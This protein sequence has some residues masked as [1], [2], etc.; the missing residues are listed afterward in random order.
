MIYTGDCVVSDEAARAL[1]RAEARADSFLVHAGH[2]EQSFLVDKL[3][4]E[5]RARE[6]KQMPIDVT[7]G[8]PLV[9][10]P[11]P[12]GFLERMLRPWIAA[13]ALDN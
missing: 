3:T 13:G 6:G 9:P 1:K 2:P 7:T 8:A 12:A 10:S 5:L 11:L 4:G